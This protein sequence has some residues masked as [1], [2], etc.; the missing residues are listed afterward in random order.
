MGLR[1]GNLGMDGQGIGGVGG[2]TEVKMNHR[3]ADSLPESPRETVCNSRIMDRDD[4]RRRIASLSAAALFAG[5]PALRASSG[6][7]ACFGG[8]VHRERRN[9]SQGVLLA[10]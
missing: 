4:E 3:P 8:S 5:R 2:L 1:K 7:S 10:A 9:G 6:T